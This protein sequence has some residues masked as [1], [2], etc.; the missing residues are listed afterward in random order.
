[1]DARFAFAVL[2][3]AVCGQAGY[4]EVSLSV[5]YGVVKVKIERRLATIGQ[6][7]SAIGL[8]LNFVI[9]AF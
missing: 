5:R 9:A 3:V 4:W 6:F 1:M 2:K 7:N 8:L